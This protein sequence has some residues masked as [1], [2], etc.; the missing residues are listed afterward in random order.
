VQAARS[1]GLVAE[2]IL[3]TG[4]VAWLISILLNVFI[5]PGMVGWLMAKASGKR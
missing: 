2:N 5:V 3:G 4:I 1:S